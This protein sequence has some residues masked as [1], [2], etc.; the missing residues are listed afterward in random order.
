[1]EWIPIVIS[2][3]NVA[4]VQTIT[5]KG[6][7]LI[8]VRNGGKFHVFSNKCPHAGADLSAAWCDK[9]YLICPVHRYKYNFENGRG[10]VGQGDYL[11]TYP[12]KLIGDNLFVGLKKPWFKFW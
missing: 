12:V 4:D 10:A 3:L 5:V 11:K 6:N 9:G 1:M 7:R 2:F 8:L